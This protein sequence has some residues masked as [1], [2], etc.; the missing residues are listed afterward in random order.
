[1][2]QVLLDNFLSILFDAPNTFYEIMELTTF[3]FS[4][5]L[6]TYKFL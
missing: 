5:F 3:A 4:Y 1:M 2:W 6:H